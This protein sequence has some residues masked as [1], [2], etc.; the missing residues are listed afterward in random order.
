MCKFLIIGF[1]R[2]LN[3]I[4]TDLRPAMD[5]VIVKKQLVVDFKML[6]IESSCFPNE[7]YTIHFYL[8]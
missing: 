7:Q 6:H 1:I 8:T 3:K 4:V 5:H 2:I